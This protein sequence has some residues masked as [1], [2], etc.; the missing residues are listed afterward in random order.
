MGSLTYVS[1]RAFFIGLG[2]TGASGTGLAFW[3]RHT[4]SPEAEQVCTSMR[5]LGYTPTKIPLAF[6]GKFDPSQVEW[7]IEC[8]Y[9]WERKRRYGN[10]VADAVGERLVQELSQCCDRKL[11]TI[12]EYER[13]T[14]VV[15]A[16]TLQ[17]IDWNQLPQLYFGLPAEYVPLIEHAASHITGRMLLSYALTEHRAS[18][19]DG[20]L[21][22]DY[23]DFMLQYGGS[24][25]IERIPAGGDRFTSYG[26][27]QFTQWALYAHHRKRRGASIVN[28]ALPSD[29]R[30]PGSVG[31]LRGT[32]HIKAACLFAIHNIVEL[33]RRTNT[34]ERRALARLLPSRGSSDSL[35]GRLSSALHAT[36]A[37]HVLRSFA[38]FIGAAHHLPAPAY[39][40]GVRWLAAEG[41]EAFSSCISHARLRSYATITAANYAAL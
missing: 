26:P 38:E 11:M 8:Q 9:Q 27:Y 34:T 1:R 3:A 25:F 14:D 33:V 31:L 13:V 35:V 36:A 41:K 21:N 6:R 29:E 12:S 32:D 20:A 37:P 16:R 30:I 19:T 18:G 10:P 28:E 5:P 23:F 15:V 39:T 4:A 2:T 40:A 7:T 17:S 24:E 22:K